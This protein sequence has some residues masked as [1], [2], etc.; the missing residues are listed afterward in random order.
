MS[1]YVRGRAIRSVEARNAEHTA[2]A[3]EVKSPCDNRPPPPNPA[4]TRRGTS[5]SP[6]SRRLVT[7]PAS[8][9]CA[10]EHLCLTLGRAREVPFVVEAV[11]PAGQPQPRQRI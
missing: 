7:P 8:P 2:L 11:A 5:G 6:M 9:L 10:A 1:E 3:R 4:S